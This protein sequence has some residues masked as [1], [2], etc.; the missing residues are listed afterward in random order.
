MNSKNVR[1]FHAS[2]TAG[3]ILGWIGLSLA[4]LGCGEGDTAVAPQGDTRVR[5]DEGIVILADQRPTEAQ[6][7][8]MVAA[9]DALFTTLSGRL[10]EAM[11]GGPANAIAVCQREAGELAAEVGRTHNVKIGRTGVRLRNQ[12]NQAPAWANDWIEQAVAEPQFAVLS[13]QQAAALLPI[14]LQPQCVMCHGPTEQILPEVKS[15]LVDRYPQDQATGF[16]VGELRGWF[17]I[18]LP[19]SAAPEAGG[20]TANTDATGESEPASTD[21]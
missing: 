10:M 19:P 12:R 6:I 11:G 13:N 9:K 1:T 8:A 3:V 21:G 18:E 20:P 14:K 16:A 17:W 15:A 7:Q 2:H 4:L 5:P